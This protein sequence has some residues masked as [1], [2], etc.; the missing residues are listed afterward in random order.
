MDRKKSRL[1]ILCN[2]MLCYLNIQFLYQF[3]SHFKKFSEINFIDRNILQY[4]MSL[5]I[6]NAMHTHHYH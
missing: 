1:V 3:L 2:V 5:Q 4:T 6:V